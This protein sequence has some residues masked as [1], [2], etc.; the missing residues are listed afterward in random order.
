[1]V[2]SGSD[3]RTAGHAG[4][5]TLVTPI[6]VLSDV[7]VAISVDGFARLRFVFSAPE[8][9]AITAVALAPLLVLL[10]WSRRRAL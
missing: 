1:M 2:V 10:G 6:R 5:M 8:P 9:A 3:V 7:D 4:S